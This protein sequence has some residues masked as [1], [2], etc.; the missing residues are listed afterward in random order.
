MFLINSNETLLNPIKIP[1]KHANIIAYIKLDT[2]T[3]YVES[4][5]ELSAF[6]ASVFEAL[7]MA[8]NKIQATT[9]IAPIKSLIEIFWPYEKKNHTN[10][11]TSDVLNIVAIIPLFTPDWAAK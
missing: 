8:I 7:P 1:V 2:F 4:S 5:S 3:S 9:N 6:S 10:T 11:T